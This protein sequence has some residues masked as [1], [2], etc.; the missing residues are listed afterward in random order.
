[1]R[2]HLSRILFGIATL[3]L[4]IAAA[5]DAGR[6]GDAA[7]PRIQL[8]LIAPAAPGGGWDSFGRE[9]QQGLRA[10]N[11]VNTVRVVNVPGAAGTIGLNQFVQMEGRDDVM[12]VTG[13]VMVGGIILQDSAATLDD[14]TPIA[15]LAD[16]YNVLVVHAASPYQDLDDFMEAWRERPGIS[17]AGGSLGSIDHLLTGTLALEAG[18]DPTDA[19]YIAYSG[20]GEVIQ[21]MLS[22][23]ATAAISG[24]N[25]FADQIEVGTLRALALSSE[26][27]LPGVDIPTFIEQGVDVAMS[28]WRGFVAAPGITDEIRD[29]LV[30]IATELRATDDWAGAGGTLDRNDWADEFM[31]G[32]EF[33][34]FLDAEAE[35]TELIIRELGL[36][37]GAGR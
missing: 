31:T 35:R 30:Q 23:S 27:R 34:Q 4:V 11:V 9:A 19:N 15:R 29:E 33:Q 2:S 16:D 24:Y 14:V 5:N 28:N 7:S 32:E 12:M 36:L 6:S 18:I 21:A 13:G 8:T 22:Q 37:A 1:M 20:G 25:E 17:V 26:E 3:A 10:N